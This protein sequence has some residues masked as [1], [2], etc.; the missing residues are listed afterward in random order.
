[1]DGDLQPMPRPALKQARD[2]VRLLT[3][4]LQFIAA[5]RLRG[6]GCPCNVVLE[7]VEKIALAAIDGTLDSHMIAHVEKTISTDEG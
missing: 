5:A 4:G 3:T 7:A 2:R 6:K 1:M